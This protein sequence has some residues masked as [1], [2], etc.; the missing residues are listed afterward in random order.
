[1][2][3]CNLKCDI[4]VIG[5]GISGICAAI[6]AGRS[7]M[8]TILLEKDEVLGGNSGPNLGVETRGAQHYNRYGQETGIIHEI[9]NEE[10]WCCASTPVAGMPYNISRRREAVLQEFLTKAGVT[11]LKSHYARQPIMEGSK[12]VGV[13]VENMAAYT[14]MTIYADVVIDASGDGNISALAQAEFRVAPE[15]RS[16]HNERCAPELPGTMIQGTSFTAIV[17]KTDH[18]VPFVPPAGTPPYAPRT[19]ENSLSF[20]YNHLKGNKISYGSVGNFGSSVPVGTIRFLYVTEAGGD[21]D[22]IADADVI[23][24]QLLQQLWSFWDHQKNGPDAELMRQWDILWVSPKAGKRQSRRF[25][26]DYILTQTDIENGCRFDDEIAYGGHNMDEHL[27]FGA[28]C[29]IYTHSMPPMYAIPYRC[30][31]SRNVDNLFLAGRLI[32]ATHLAHASSR[33]MRTGGAIGQAVGLA[34]AWCCK[35]SCTPRELG[36]KFLTPYLTELRDL[37][38]SLPPKATFIPGDLAPLATVSADA[39]ELFNEQTPDISIPLFTPA[40]AYIYH[41]QKKIDSIQLFLNNPTGEA[42]KLR[43]NLAHAEPEHKWMLRHEFDEFYRNRPFA[44]EFRQLTAGEAEIPA[45]FNGWYTLVPPTV[46]LPEKDRF[47]DGDRLLLTLHP[48]NP[49]LR[50]SMALKVNEVCR[51][52]EYD[53]HRAAWMP[54]AATPALKIFPAPDY[55]E[56]VNVI[57]GRN[58]RYVSAPGDQWL[59]PWNRTRRQLDFVWEKEQ[60]ISRAVIYFDNLEAD[61]SENPW[62]NRTRISK[63]LVKDYTLTAETADGKVVLCEVKNNR[64]RRAEHRFQP[65]KTKHISLEI[66]DVY[67]DCVRVYEVNFF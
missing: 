66:N 63:H 39:E 20:Y 37:D 7:G 11:I 65:V 15:S 51:A 1:M 67:G 45:G 35:K 22:T 9:E 62:R 14:T 48:G 10:A 16:Q 4:L 57:N 21:L 32:S 30:C 33:I 60:T 38:G 56:A 55:G 58:R 41:W 26:G 28:E 18:D 52:V 3:T 53:D 12:I 40:G 49:M 29:S 2:D 42:V 27:S 36:E 61:V 50:W 19:W 17:I 47:N 64:I 24:E 13:T 44:G 23:Y 6:Q 46:E 54:F 31:Y 8:K 25:I 59:A 5:S 43:V 34:A